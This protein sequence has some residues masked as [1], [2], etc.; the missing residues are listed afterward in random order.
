MWLSLKEFDTYLFLAI[1]RSFSHGFLDRFFLVATEP[2]YYVI[3]ALLVFAYFL[4]NNWKRTMVVVT[5]AAITLAITDTLCDEALKPFFSR[6]RPCHP[7][8]GVAGAICLDGFKSSY[9]FPSAHAMN[10]FA[11]ATLF[12]FLYPAKSVYFFIFAFIIGLSRI[13]IGVHFP[14]DVVGGAIVGSVIAMGVY[15][16]YTLMQKVRA[17]SA[18]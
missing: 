13:Y 9:S 12:A 1:N 6:L 3:P 5:L 17:V 7:R 4:K 14:F 11:Q 2:V 16:G 10:I 18:D 15:G 8:L